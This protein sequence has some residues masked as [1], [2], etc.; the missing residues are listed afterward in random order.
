MQILRQNSL[1][2]IVEPGQLISWN[3]SAR[4]SSILDVFALRFIMLDV[5]VIRSYMLNVF[6]MRFNI[7]EVLV[8]RFNMLDVFITRSNVLDVFVMRSNMLDL[9]SQIVTLDLT[10]PDCTDHWLLTYSREQIL[11]ITLGKLHLVQALIF[12]NYIK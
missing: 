9:S 12:L 3:N 2:Y 7:L 11:C 10:R 6:I 5:F 4:K 8:M 1:C